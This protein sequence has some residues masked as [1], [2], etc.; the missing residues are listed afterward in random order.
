VPLSIKTKIDQTFHYF[1]AGTINIDLT[2]FTVLYIKY[3]AK[4]KTPAIKK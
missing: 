3:N 1:N 2:L 4:I